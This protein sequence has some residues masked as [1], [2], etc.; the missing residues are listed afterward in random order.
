M[1]RKEYLEKKEKFTSIS[2]RGKEVKSE[3]KFVPQEEAEALKRVQARQRERA[4]AKKRREKKLDLFWKNK[5][6]PGETF[7][8]IQL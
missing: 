5:N 4:R 1:S 3:D 8:E 6:K 2:V 7:S